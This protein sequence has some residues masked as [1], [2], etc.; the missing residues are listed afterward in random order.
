MSATTGDLSDNH[1][2]LSVRL[3]ELDTPVDVRKNQINF[4]YLIIL[5]IM[6]FSKKKFQFQPKDVED[7]SKIIPSATFFES[8]RGMLFYNIY[9]IF[10]E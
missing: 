9:L 4:V 10:I 2:I 3:Y 5:L 7:R 6:S 1:E 8:P